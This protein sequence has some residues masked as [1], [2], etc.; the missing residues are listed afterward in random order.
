MRVR[1]SRDL[2]AA[3]RQ[4][5]RSLRLTQAGLAARAGVTRTWLS[6]VENGKPGAEVGMILRTLDVLDLAIDL[7]PAGPRHGGFDLD[8]LLGVDDG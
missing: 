2:G 3:I 1:T 4:A 7:Q 5:R 8:A 6:S